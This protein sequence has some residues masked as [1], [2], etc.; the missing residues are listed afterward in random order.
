MLLDPDTLALAARGADAMEGLPAAV[1][2]HLTGETHG[3]ALELSTAP[4]VSVP[5]LGDR[6]QLHRAGVARELAQLGLAVASA[7]THPLAVWTE[8]EVSA[9]PRYRQVHESMRE[10]ARREPTFALHIHVG[11]DE[12]ERATLLHDRLRAHLPLLLALSAN[13]PFWQGRDSGLASARTSIFQAFPR[14]G[15]P[16]GFGSY[17]EWV[18]AVDVMLR[19]GAFDDP[20]FLWWDVRLQPRFGTVEVRIMDAQACAADTVALCA[21]VQSVARLELEEGYA[22]PRLLSAPEVLDENRFLAARDGMDA[23]F[24]DPDGDR[25]V[26]ARGVLSRLLAA[27]APHAAALD[28]AEALTSV[29]T[30][31]RSTGAERQRRTA[32]DAGGLEAVVADLALG[33]LEPAASR[34]YAA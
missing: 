34:T 25:R 33:Y 20:T 12:A 31:G 21:L 17:D 16:R 18:E 23:A 15:I 32:A 30:L 9:T 27:A 29:E 19:C 10:L 5:T 14:V 4:E 22:S 1:R 11:V 7:G 2:D 13:S 26:P 28:C 6:L 24:L 3:C 8:I